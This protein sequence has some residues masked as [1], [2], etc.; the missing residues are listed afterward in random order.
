MK[1]IFYTLLILTL[2]ITGCGKDK[3]MDSPSEK[4][5]KYLDSYINLDDNILTDFNDMVDSIKDY[6]TDQKDKYKDIMKH[7]YKNITY[8]IK[9]EIID[10]DQATVEV[11]IEVYDQSTVINDEYDEEDFLDEDGEYDVEKFNDYQLCLLDKVD[12]KTK[13]TVI[14]YL[15]K[16]DDVWVINEPNEI[17]KQK[18]HGIYG[19]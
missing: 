15:S 18:I 3:K 6:T 5:R 16:Q 9:N 13:Y 4:V 10:D 11:E 12:T 7:H 1:K 19:Y 14:F 8:E 17:V 2:F